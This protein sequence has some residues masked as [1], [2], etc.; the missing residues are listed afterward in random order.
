ME[1]GL[2]ESY[3]QEW[4]EKDIYENRSFRS[5]NEIRSKKIVPSGV[6]QENRTKVS[7]LQELKEELGLEN[8]NPRTRK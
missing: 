6:G 2:R 8:S 5:R 7:Y 1:V 3:F 4:E